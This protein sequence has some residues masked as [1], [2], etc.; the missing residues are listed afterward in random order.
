MA[1]IRSPVVLGAL[2]ASSVL[3]F[4]PVAAAAATCDPLLKGEPA[5]FE[6]SFALRGRERVTHAL[7]V[8]ANSNLIVL[9]QERGLDATLEVARNSRVLVRADN[10]V[11]R[12]GI[13]RLTFVTALNAEAYAINLIGKEETDVAGT[14]DV[15]VVAVPGDACGEVHRTLAAA[16]ANFAAG[17]SVT[18]GTVSPV[19]VADAPSAY[20]AAAKNG[21]TDGDEHH[22]SAGAISDKLPCVYA[23]QLHGD[24]EGTAVR[25][26]H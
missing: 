5:S 14:V 26:L 20:A 22:E 9:A 24:D 4:L 6:K 25:R 2:L 10:A 17:Q 13:Q 11:R 1:P 12:T 8:P 16:D 23:C 3:P 15:R 18:Q 21:D 19:P 7:T